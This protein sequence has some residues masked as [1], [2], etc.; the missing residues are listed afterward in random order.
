MDD[1]SQLI[2]PIARELLGEP[3]RAYSTAKELRFGTRGSMS[4]DLEKGTFFD[5][6]TGE[7]GGVTAL[8]AREAKVEPS[9]WLTA[10]GY[11]EAPQRKPNGSTSAPQRRIDKTFDYRDAD[12]T[13]L[14]QVV[15]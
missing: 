12:G 8:I 11:G 15:R 5:F 14:L 1:W 6:E 10:R 3:N 7:G 4:V 13:L 9:T 2:E